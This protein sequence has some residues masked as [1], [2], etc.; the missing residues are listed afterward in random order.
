MGP[1]QA[2]IP[3]ARAADL[4]E[5]LLLVRGAG[6][7]RACSSALGLAREA[8]HSGSQFAEA[9]PVE[10]AMIQAAQRFESAPPSKYQVII[11]GA[12]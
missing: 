4:V 9:P 11:R 10:L 5:L 12:E 3:P 1:R 2:T 7:A 6:Q 8:A